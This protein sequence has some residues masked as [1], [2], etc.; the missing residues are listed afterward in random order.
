MSITVRKGFRSFTLFRQKLSRDQQMPKYI[1]RLTSKIR[2]SQ[3]LVSWLVSCYSV[4]PDEAVNVSLDRQSALK[5]K[6]PRFHDNV[7]INGSAPVR[8]F[9]DFLGWPT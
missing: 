5:R 7:A 1:L 4:G 9:F 2:K 3:K 8:P 6:G